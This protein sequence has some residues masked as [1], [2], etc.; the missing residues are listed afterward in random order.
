MS[1]TGTSSPSTG[2]HTQAFVRRSGMGAVLLAVW[3]LAGWFA[4]SLSA[5]GNAPAARVS[6]PARIA[7]FLEVTGFDTALESIAL[8]ASDAPQMLGRDVSDFGADW[9]R[10]AESVFDLAV[11]RGL[12]SD[13]LERALTEDMLTHAVEFYASPLGIRLVE[14]ENAAHLN[15]DPDSARRA[16]MEIIAD[17]LHEGAPRLELLQRM[18]PAIDPKDSAVHAVEEIQVRFLLSAAAAGVVDMPVDEATLRAIME[19]QRPTLLRAMR[20]SGLAQSA[21]VYRDF[22]DSDLEAYV[23]ALENP[24]MQRVYELMN[25]IQYEVMANRFEVLAGRMADLHP[26]QEL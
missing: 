26:G 3:L 12:A 21:Y 25:A 2:S 23:E 6:D 13:I 22:D 24:E 9:T 20:E 15:D 5:Q 19:E 4:T 10:T 16:G 7:A 11:M 17:L 8:S 18:G 14:V 1:Y